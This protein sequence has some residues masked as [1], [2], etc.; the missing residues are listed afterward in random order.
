VLGEIGELVAQL[1]LVG[2]GLLGELAVGGHRHSVG[3]VPLQPVVPAHDRGHAGADRDE[4]GQNDADRG[5]VGV[6]LAARIW[7]AVI[8]RSL[9][10][11]AG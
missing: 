2:H 5:V 7:V 8:G 3:A 9:S 11:T 6:P 1:G 4:D 10:L